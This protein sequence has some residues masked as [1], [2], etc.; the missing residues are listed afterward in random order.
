LKEDIGAKLNLYFPQV[1]ITNLEVTAVE[2]RNQINVVLDYK[3][4]QTN[5]T[6]TIEITLS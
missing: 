5:D 6:D 2:D 4:S 3:I 1:Q